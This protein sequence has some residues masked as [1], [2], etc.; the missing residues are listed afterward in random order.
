MGIAGFGK[1]AFIVVLT[2]RAVAP[3]KLVLTKFKYNSSFG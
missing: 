3:W 2:G 1:H